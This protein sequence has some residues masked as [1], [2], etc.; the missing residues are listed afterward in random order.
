LPDRFGLDS[1]RQAEWQ[2]LAEAV[3]RAVE[4]ELTQQQRQ[5]FVALVLNGVPLDSLA[6]ELGSTR[7]AIY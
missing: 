1:A 4:E 2:D 6:A 3:R 5:N 7:N